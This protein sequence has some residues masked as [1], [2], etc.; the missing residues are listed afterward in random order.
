MGWLGVKAAALARCRVSSFRHC[1]QVLL[2]TITPYSYEKVASFP[3][4]PVLGR[5]AE[6]FGCPF[7]LQP[8]NH[9]RRHHFGLYL[10]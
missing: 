8:R 7:G 4:F 10:G 6:R 5:R 9:L 2:T 1:V 3:A